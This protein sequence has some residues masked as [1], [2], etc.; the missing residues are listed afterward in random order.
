VSPRIILLKRRSKKR[1]AAGIRRWIKIMPCCV[2][3]FAMR[4]CLRNIS[5]GAI[6][7]N[8]LSMA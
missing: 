2:G 8:P 7:Q 3:I 1:D 5:T 6:A 4:E